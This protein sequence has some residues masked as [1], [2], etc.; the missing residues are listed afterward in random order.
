MSNAK[1]F[2]E[3][4]KGYGQTIR[5][6]HELVS[7][8]TGMQQLDIFENES[9][10]RVM[11]LDGFLMLTEKHEFTY[12]ELLVHP[13]LFAHPSPAQVLIIGGGDGGTLR[14][15][16]KHPEVERAVLCEIDEMVITESKKH[17]PFVACGFDSPKAEVFVGDGIE[18]IRQHKNSFDVI[19]VDSTD[20][21]G[22]A[23]GL[24]RS[25]FYEDCNRA[26]KSGGIFV[27]QAESP[28]YQLEPWKRTFLEL[29]Q[30]FK[31]IA[32]YGG[33]IPMYPS[34]YW[35][36]AFASQSRTPHE[37][38]NRQRVE[39]MKG[40]RYYTAETQNSAFHLPA[41]A[42]TLYQELISEGQ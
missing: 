35:T 29:R 39:N 25:P 38:F 33:A 5:I 19:I 2:K 27:Q 40:L 20:P 10:G 42:Q 3:A 37:H 41:F 34:G 4:E 32:A 18:Y 15:V 12:H 36:F 7:V 13:T 11:A 14:E 28:F 30:V 9:V 6:D 17:L 23:E 1:W 22:F 31:N 24:F 16:T 26:L 21:I 8:H